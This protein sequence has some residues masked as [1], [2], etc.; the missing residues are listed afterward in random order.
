MSEGV[1]GRTVESYDDFFADDPQPRIWES[2]NGDDPQMP[3]RAYFGMAPCG[4]RFHFNERHVVVRNDDG[5]FTVSPQPTP[6]EGQNSILCR[7]CGWHGYIDHNVW[8]S[9]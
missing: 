2:Q 6:P 3:V 7:Q 4:H 9:V 1:Q 8:T 5:T